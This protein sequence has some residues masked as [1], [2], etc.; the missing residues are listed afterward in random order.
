M[1]VIAAGAALAAAVC[2]AEANAA[3]RRPALLG[4]HLDAH[5]G[6]RSRVVLRWSDPVRIRHSRP[7]L[8]LAATGSRRHGRLL[9]RHPGRAQ[10]LLASST[11]PVQAAQVLA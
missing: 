2:P 11:E 6:A 8:F 3:R 10:T 4:A 5:G 9:S 1:A 7:V